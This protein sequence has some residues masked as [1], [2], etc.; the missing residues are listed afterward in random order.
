MTKFVNANNESLLEIKT[1][2]ITANTSS[3][4]T[5]A[6]N[7]NSNEVMIISCICDNYIAVPYVINEKYF[8]AFQSFQNLGGSIYAFG[9]VTNKS[10]TVTIRYVDIK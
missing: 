4:S 6:T 5:I 10:L 9:G 8:I 3:G 7:L 1:T 2:S